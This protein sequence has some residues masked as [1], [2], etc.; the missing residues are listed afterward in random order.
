M[1]MYI[2]SFNELTTS[3]LFEILRV[4]CAVFIVE[5]N[6][7][8]QDIDE[9]DRRALHVFLRDG[10]EIA[11]Y[12][13]IFEKDAQRVQIGRVLTTRR[14]KGYGAAVM[15]AGLDA[16]QS[17]FTQPEI[18]LEAQ[19]YA[20]GFYEKFGFSVCSDEFLED[21]IP[22]VEMTRATKEESRASI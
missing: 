11:A 21:G 1:Q 12:L 2:K 5:Q 22:H 13:R 19:T 3:E 8:Y 10:E 7:P 20:V 4:R 9:I 17:Y 16:L 15:R 6:C 18:Y 14:G